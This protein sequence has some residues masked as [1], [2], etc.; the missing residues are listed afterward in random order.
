MTSLKDTDRFDD[1]DLLPYSRKV[2]V[3]FVNPNN[4]GYETKAK[5]LA[6]EIEFEHGVT[7]QI[8]HGARGGRDYC[9][10]L[11]IDKWLLGRKVI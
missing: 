4:P 6:E 10:N 11:R 3:L 8:N 9:S 1:L 2:V 7:V 5:T